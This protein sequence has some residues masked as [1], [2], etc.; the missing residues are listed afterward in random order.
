M[1]MQSRAFSESLYFALYLSDRLR[2][3]CVVSASS[4]V[5]GDSLVA[6]TFLQTLFDMTAIIAT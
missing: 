6:A 3:G 1:R 5:R 2:P 4:K